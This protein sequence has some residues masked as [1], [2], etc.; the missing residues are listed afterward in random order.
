MQL[1]LF[2]QKATGKRL[3][4]MEASPDYKDGQ[5]HNLSTTNMM[6]DN[7]GMSKM[8]A[9]KFNEVKYGL[10]PKDNIP[11][12]KTDL[13]SI[14]VDRDISIWFG[15]SSYYIQIDGK[16]F[17]VDPVFSKYASP[18]P[19]I[20]PAFKGTSIYST[21]D[22]PVID[23]LLIT[24][25][26]YDHLDYKTVKK[27][28]EKV[29]LVVC[30]LGVGAHLEKWG[31]PKE[32]IIEMDWNE[33]KELSKGFV[34][35]AKPTRHFSGRSFKRNPTLW[36]SFVLQT[37]SM[38]LFLS[39]DGGYDSHFE[40]IGKEFGKIDLAFLE[41]GQ[42]NE[43]WKHIHSLPE[44]VCFEAKDLNATRIIPIHWGK[45]ALADHPWKEPI[46]KL[47]EI[48]KEKNLRLITP[49][50]GEIIELKNESQ[51]F[52]LWWEDLK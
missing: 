34:I 8:M 39:G 48:S 6:V 35:N 42:Y 18:I 46:E 30:G 52:S 5:F 7:K 1:P 4:R 47:M 14:S 29:K 10:R 26:H 22:M 13:K 16:R 50:I 36:L 2:G 11:A 40:E 37:P 24:H 21:D 41:T 23:Y 27:L 44:Q 28:K 49:M 19:I 9:R 25:D 17:L 15:H 32:K 33:S 51:V 12:I 45:F 31:Y 3:E 38:N 43:K 20:I